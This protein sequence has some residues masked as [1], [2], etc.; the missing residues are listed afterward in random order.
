MT[1]LNRVSLIGRLTNDFG[2][3]NKSYS[4]LPTGTAKMNISIAVNSSH[5]K[6][7]EWVNESSFFDIVIFGKMAENLKMRLLKGKQVAVAGHLKQDR[8]KDKETGANKSRIYIIADSI[9][10]L[11]SKIENENNGNARNQSFAENNSV[12]TNEFTE[13]VPF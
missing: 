6:G 5:K 12:S 13:D 10:L 4:V 11:G 1:D 9:Q 3:D 2:T 8:W 7:E